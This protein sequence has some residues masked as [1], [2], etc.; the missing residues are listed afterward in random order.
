MTVRRVV[1]DPG[2]SGLRL[3]SFDDP[4][5]PKDGLLASVSYGGVCGTDAHRLAGHLP[6]P[7][8]PIALGH[9]AVGIV[10]AVG[11]A[12]TSDSA[13]TPLHLGDRILWYS[14]AACGHCRSCT[15]DRDPSTCA[16][17]RWPYPAHEDGPAGF[18]E[19]AAI[20]PNVPMYRVPDILPLEAAAA[21]G[22]AMP[23]ALS[24]LDQ[25]GEIRRGSVAVVLGSGPVGLA[26][27][28]AMSDLPL[29]RL[30]VVGTGEERLR[31]AAAFGATDVL[32]IAATTVEQRRMAV[33]DAS[34]GRGADLVFEAAGV[35][36]AFTD[37]I[38]LL[39]VR[40]TLAIVGLYSGEA[41]AAVDPVLLNNRK[42]RIVGCLGSD[43]GH[44]FRGIELLAR[45]Q[46]RSPLEGVVSPQV[47][48]LGQ[49]EEAIRALG[50]GALVK[51]YIAPALDA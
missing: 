43:P 44:L 16:N 5:V 26:A 23:T 40:G 27:T 13:G 38:E 9:E 35:P 37:G 15:I 25:V 24:A 36:A 34:D 17:L 22:C 45:F 3:E 47:F 48:P 10:T 41:T 4:I 28:L 51:A 14:P 11:G 31:A 12:R 49:A 29:A 33:L 7:P 18:Q 21:F 8:G 6:A 20:A 46:E 19:V 30:I 32:D 2:T 42:L 50:S 39:A 1:Y